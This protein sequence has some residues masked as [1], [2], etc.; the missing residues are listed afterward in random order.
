MGKIHY[1]LKLTSCSLDLYVPTNILTTNVVSLINNLKMLPGGIHWHLQLQ[2]DY[3]NNLLL[4]VGFLEK[5]L[6]GTIL[7]KLEIVGF[8]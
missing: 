1:F 5:S 4:E 7:L 6:L 3:L 2:G 8:L